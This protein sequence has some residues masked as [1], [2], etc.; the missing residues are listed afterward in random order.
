[1]GSY[2]WIK[3]YCPIWSFL[4]NTFY[5]IT[6]IKYLKETLSINKELKNSIETVE[7]I[8]IALSNFH[9]IPDEIRDWLPWVI[10]LIHRGYKDDCDGAAVLSKFL[11]KQIGIGGKIVSL[12][13]DYTGHA[14]FVSNDKKY[15]ATNN[16]IVEDN[17]TDNKILEFFNNKY[18]RMIK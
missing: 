18:N 9:W 5:W 14:I 17:W 8:K 3:I 2:L 6:K 7:N 13:G 1:M 16:I 10:T 11:F 15:M 12:L 4:V